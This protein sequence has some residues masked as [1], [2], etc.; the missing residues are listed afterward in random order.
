MQWR[1]ASGLYQEPSFIDVAFFL[2]LLVRKELAV[3]FIKVYISLPSVGSGTL[4]IL[5]GS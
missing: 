5:Y 1:V 4:R 3:A 2:A